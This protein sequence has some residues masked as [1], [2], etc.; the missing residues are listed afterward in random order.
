MLVVKAKVQPGETILIHNGSSAIGLATIAV[1]ISYGCTIFTTVAT[2]EQKA[3]IL[4]RFNTVST[5]WNCY[6]VLKS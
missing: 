5:I 6:Q 2:D 4:K 3:F 1:A